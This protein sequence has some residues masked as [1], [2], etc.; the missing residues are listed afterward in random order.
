MTTRIEMDAVVKEYALRMLKSVFYGPKRLL[1]LKNENDDRLKERV[2]MSVL[3]GIV[4]SG[5]AN[6]RYDDNRMIDELP[7]SETLI[8]KWGRYSLG[9]L[10]PM[11]GRVG[12]F[13]RSAD[14][15]LGLSR[16]AHS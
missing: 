13:L 8:Q 11:T 12:K 16:R 4:R 7:A 10:S 6:H 9:R 14:V 2:F 3:E 5:A 15:D 1:A